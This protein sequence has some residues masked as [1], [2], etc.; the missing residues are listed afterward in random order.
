MDL[1]TGKA[2]FSKAKKISNANPQMSKY[3]WG[4]VDIVNWKD[5]AG[6]DY[7]GL[8]YKPE[9][10]DQSQKYP[11]IVYFYEKYTDRYYAHYSP[12][13]SRSTVNFPLYNSNGYL[14]F[15]P[16]IT[17]INGYPGKSAYNAI[18]SGTNA[19]LEKGFVDKYRLGLQGQSWGGY[20]T[21]YMVTQTNLFTAAMAGAPVSNMTSAYGGIR[22]ESGMVRQFQYE[23]G[24]SRIG[25]TLWEKLD[26]YIENS[27]LFFTN[28][29]E[30]P[31]LIMANDNDG[32]V[33]WQ[34]GIEYFSA[35]RRLNKPVWMLTY[36]GDEHNL[37]KWPNRVDLSI[38]MLQFFN[39]YLQNKPMPVWMKEGIKA[40][41]KGI[42]TGYEL[43]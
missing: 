25:G 13:P 24:Q 36:N 17:Y 21:A 23:Q 7:K 2:D 38:R 26:L 33:P 27:P 18:M 35:L 16:D 29:V 5:S 34:Q 28:K 14:I 8:L 37:T 39:H 31:L 20:Q 6:I 4:T 10:F 19:M 43:N 42:K 41:E 30:T 32:A 11:M 15:V 9:N 3:L 1:W 12:N 22:W 40:T